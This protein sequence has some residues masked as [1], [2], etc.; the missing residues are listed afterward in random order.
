M[1][2]V[3]DST[4]TFDE[5][6]TS[7]FETFD[8]TNW[9]VRLVGNTPSTNVY[10]R[11][12][13]KHLGVSLPDQAS[14]LELALLFNPIGHETNN[15]IDEPAIYLE[16]HPLNSTGILLDDTIFTFKEH[17]G[18][19]YATVE[20][21]KL[22]EPRFS[23]DEKVRMVPRKYLLPSISLD[24][25]PTNLFPIAD[26]K[27]WFHERYRLWSAVLQAETAKESKKYFVP[28]IAHNIAFQTMLLNLFSAENPHALE[29]PRQ[30]TLP[31]QDRV[32]VFN[33]HKVFEEFKLGQFAPLYE[34]FSQFF[35]AK[36]KTLDIYFSRVAQNDW[37]FVELAIGLMA[38]MSY[39]SVFLSE[40][41]P[42][43]QAY[44]CA[45]G[46]PMIADGIY[47]TRHNLFRP[48]LG[49]R[50][51]IIGSLRDHYKA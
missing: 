24:P 26:L 2:S 27:H 11:N 44:V 15:T 29:P 33:I 30:K 47:R 12:L 3:I 22:K 49:P 23:I 1:H 25:F 45:A 28:Y 48:D 13:A 10:A 39:G 41:V 40:N 43:W 18:I 21:K 4:D 5:T 37:S 32:A 20:P 46:I 9:R 6:T 38:G 51:G 17:Q 14:D 19:H 34:K 35:I 16:L 7:F 42:P 31:A 8:K 36:G 50:T